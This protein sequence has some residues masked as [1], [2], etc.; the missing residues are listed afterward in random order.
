M[1]SSF[2]FKL[3]AQPQCVQCFSLWSVRLKLCAQSD[4]APP[5]RHAARKL[6][7]AALKLLRSKAK[8]A[9]KHKH[10]LRSSCSSHNRMLTAV[11]PR[12][13]VAQKLSSNVAAQR[14]GVRSIA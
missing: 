4:A 9:L 2:A 6:D 3:G 10:K 14:Y 8:A 12:L 5:E 11:P 7:Q 13:A 1:R